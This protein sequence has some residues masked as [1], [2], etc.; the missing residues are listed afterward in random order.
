VL[1]TGV[2]ALSPAA[3]AQTN[4]NSKLQIY[5]VGSAEALRRRIVNR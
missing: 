3:R 4:K 5:H 1:A 2:A